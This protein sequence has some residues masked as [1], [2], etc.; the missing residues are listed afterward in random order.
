LGGTGL[1]LAIID[2]VAASNGG[3]AHLANRDGGGADLWISLPRR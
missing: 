2:A 1:G 3:T